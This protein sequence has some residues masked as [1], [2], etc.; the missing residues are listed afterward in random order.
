MGISKKKCCMLTGAV[1]FQIISLT[2]LGVGIFL[3]PLADSAVNFKLADMLTQ[4]K[5][6]SDLWGSI[7]GKYN[8]TV[9][10]EISLFEFQNPDGVQM[11][12]EK[13][14]IKLT[15]KIPFQELQASS[16]INIIGNFVK[17]KLLV[18]KNIKRFWK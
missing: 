12:G 4:K 13:P 9:I 8:L 7:P 3:S 15:P 17:N 6:N 2:F 14:V 1:T 16:N 11:R 5:S 18:K 10:R